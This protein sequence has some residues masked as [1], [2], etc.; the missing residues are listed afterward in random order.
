MLLLA[1]VVR[2]GAFLKAHSEKGCR[3]SPLRPCQDLV[4]VFFSGLGWGQ[5]SVALF[6]EMAELLPTPQLYGDL[7]AALREARAAG[8]QPQQPPQPSQQL[9]G[10]EQAGQPLLRGPS[11]SGPQ[12]RAPSSEW[13]KRQQAGKAGAEAGGEALVLPGYLGEEGIHPNSQ[14][15]RPARRLTAAKRTRGAAGAAAASA[16]SPSSEAGR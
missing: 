3:S 8:P 1:C 6:Q 14:S 15:A 11:I 7:M 12:Q 4:S 9:Q 16:A 13:S 10:S 5:G 2:G